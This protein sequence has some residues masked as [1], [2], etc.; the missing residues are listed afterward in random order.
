MTT[1]AQSLGLDTTKHS[2]VEVLSTEDWALEM[3][4]RPV[5]A[6][7]MLYPVSAV[8]EVWRAQETSDLESRGENITPPNMVYT[9]QT[10][11]N[12]CGTIG[13]IHSVT[14]AAKTVLHVG[15]GGEEA[16]RVSVEAGSFFARIMEESEGKTSDELAAVVEGADELEDAHANAAVQGQSDVPSTDDDVDVH[17]VSLSPFRVPKKDGSE[18]E[19]ELRLFELDGRKAS[20][21]DHGVIADDGLVLERAIEVV[22]GFMARDPDELRFSMVALVKTPAASDEE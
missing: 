3:V 20:P 17:F 21:I 9:K 11:G 14:N 2:F 13:I 7:L 10:V 8:Q 1:Y 6:V 22:K 15:E 12:A 5:L 18:G 16:G 19:T 4:P